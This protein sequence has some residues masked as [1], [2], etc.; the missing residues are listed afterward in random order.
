M[1]DVQQYEIRVLKD[2]AAAVQGNTAGGIQRRGDPLLMAEAK[3]R[4]NKFRL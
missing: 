2:R 3:Q 1:L 4:L